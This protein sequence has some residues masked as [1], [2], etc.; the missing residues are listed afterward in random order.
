[1]KCLFSCEWRLLIIS[2]RIYP[3]FIYKH[4]R[5]AAAALVWWLGQ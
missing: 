2:S 4:D 1:M 5:K 3:A